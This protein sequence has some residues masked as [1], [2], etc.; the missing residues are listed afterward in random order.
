MSVGQG[1]RSPTLYFGLRPPSEQYSDIYFEAD[2]I[3]Y[4]IIG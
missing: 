1:G 4:L 3:R 2:S